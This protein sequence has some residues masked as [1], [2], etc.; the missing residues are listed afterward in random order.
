MIDKL[1]ERLG[2]ELGK[3]PNGD[4]IF[5]WVRTRDL[6]YLYE[7]G[8]YEEKKTE[9]GIYFMTPVWERHSHAEVF[10]NVW[11]LAIW[12]SPKQIVED[13]LQRSVGDPESEWNNIMHG[14]FP[15]PGNGEYGVIENILLPPGQV[16]TEQLTTYALYAAFDALTLKIPDHVRA[17]KEELDRQA[18]ADAREWD[19][20][21]DHDI[22]PWWN[23]GITQFQAGYGDSPI[24]QRG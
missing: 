17:A 19:D 10:G 5:K 23:R 12:K 7:T 9:A 6:F 3:R 21:V 18:K 15:Y 20:A 4:P 22:M 1:N 24:S 16:P 11:C 13:A 2:Q 14:S 8:K